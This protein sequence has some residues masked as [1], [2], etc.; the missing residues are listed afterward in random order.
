MRRMSPASR[1]RP[2]TVP[3]R[4]VADADAAVAGRGRHGASAQGAEDDN[5]R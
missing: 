5:D 1:G 3:Y 2:G 4:A